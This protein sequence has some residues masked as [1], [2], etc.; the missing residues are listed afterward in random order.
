[1]DSQGEF[2][3]SVAVWNSFV[4]EAVFEMSLEV[5]VEEIGMEMKGHWG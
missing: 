1:M 2:P 3:G 4:K 5:C